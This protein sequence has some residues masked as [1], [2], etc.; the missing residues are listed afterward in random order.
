MGKIITST[1]CK[2]ILQ[3]SGSTYDTTIGVLIPIVENYILRYTNLTE[4]SASAEPGLKLAAAQLINF[5]IQKPSNITS[6]TI[7]AY[8]VAY[9]QEYPKYL[10]A[11]L[12]PY[13][14]VVSYQEPYSW[15]DDIYTE[16]DEASE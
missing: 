9:S 3:I 4:D 13:R 15:S 12:K 16:F 14:L 6:E 2:A 10:T 5:Q 1:E 7:G 11:G 8:S